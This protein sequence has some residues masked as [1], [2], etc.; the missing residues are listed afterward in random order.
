MQISTMVSVFSEREVLVFQ[1]GGV[2]SAYS[3]SY[4]PRAR[5]GPE[6]NNSQC[7]GSRFLVEI[8]FGISNRP[9]TDIGHYLDTY[10][11]LLI[12]NAFLQSFLLRPRQHR[13]DYVG[14]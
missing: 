11:N 4:T 1:R 13:L 9:G 8:W 2:H 14:A 5:K 7:Y 12:P 10:S 6:S 3:P